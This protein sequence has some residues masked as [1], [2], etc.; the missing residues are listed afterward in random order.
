[1]KLKQRI[2]QRLSS[3]QATAT[4]IANEFGMPLTFITSKAAKMRKEGLI[5]IGGWTRKNGQMVR[6]LAIGAGRDALRPLSQKELQDPASRPIPAS[7]FHL[8][9]I[10][11]GDRAGWQAVNDSFMRASA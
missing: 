3:G 10:L 5:H 8:G 7:V 4:Q 9:H 1:M 11:T 2:L 6:L